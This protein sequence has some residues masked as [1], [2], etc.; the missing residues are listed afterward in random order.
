LGHT[1]NSKRN[2]EI[3][4]VDIDLFLNIVEYLNE[5]K[6]NEIYNEVITNEKTLRKTKKQREIVE[7]VAKN[8]DSITREIIIGIIAGLI[9]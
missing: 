7:T 3:V 2:S 4:I 8:I 5:E 6:Q 1:L 9:K